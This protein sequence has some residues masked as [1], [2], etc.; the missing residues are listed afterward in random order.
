MG[1]L[2]QARFQIYLS[3]SVEGITASSYSSLLSRWRFLTPH[4]YDS[5]VIHVRGPAY[6]QLYQL[7]FRTGGLR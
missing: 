1:M 7:Q 4:G 6:R 5:R 2:T 3:E